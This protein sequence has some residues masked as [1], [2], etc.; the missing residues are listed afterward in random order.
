MPLLRTFSNKWS[1]R[2]NVWSD[3]ALLWLAGF[4]NTRPVRIQKRWVI[5]RI[6]YACTEKINFPR[7]AREVGWTWF[8]C[9]IGDEG[10]PG[11]LALSR[12]FSREE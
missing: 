12:D 6:I 3:E 4:R 1:S 8:V 7:D 9:S 11:G 2:E 10:R 5:T